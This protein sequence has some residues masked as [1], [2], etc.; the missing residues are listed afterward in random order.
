MAG[1]TATAQHARQSVLAVAARRQRG[2][3]LAAV[4]LRSL[5]LVVGL[6]WI[7]VFFLANPVIRGAMDTIEYL[8]DVRP[9]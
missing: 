5:P 2:D 8:F 3:D 9:I 4:A 7:V 6:S 1:V